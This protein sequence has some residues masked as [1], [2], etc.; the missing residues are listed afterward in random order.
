MLRRSGTAYRGCQRHSSSCTVPTLRYIPTYVLHPKPSGVSH[1]LLLD[2][3]EVRLW[4]L[5][6]LYTELNDEAPCTPSRNPPHQQTPDQTRS[7]LMGSYVYGMLNWNDAAARRPSIHFSVQQDRLQ[8][9]LVRPVRCV[10][11]TTSQCYKLVYE[12]RIWNAPG[13]N[14]LTRTSTMHILSAFFWSLLL[15]T[16]VDSIVTHTPRNWR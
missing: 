4:Y 6:S 11:C 3:Q 9:E 16:L 14:R 2:K 15:P 7:S 13:R 8:H 12:S 1:H 10:R 5:R